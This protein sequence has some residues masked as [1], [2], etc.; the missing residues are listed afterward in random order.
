MV[1]LAQPQHI[2]T[3]HPKLNLNPNPQL[4]CRRG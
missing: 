3:L 1:F 2:F 4:H